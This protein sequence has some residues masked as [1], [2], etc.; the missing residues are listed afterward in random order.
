MSIKLTISILLSDRIDT[1]EKCLESIVPLLQQIPSELILTV[2]GKDPRVKQLAKQYTDHII[3]YTWI[4]DFSHA[5]NQGLMEAKGE[6]FMYMDDDEWFEDVTPIID[7]FNS[8]EYQQYNGATYRKKDYIDWEGKGYHESFCAGLVKRREDLIFIGKVHERYNCIFTPVKEI[9]AFVH[10]YGYVNKKR[11]IGNEK[12]SRNLPLL[13]DMIQ[14]EPNN[15]NVIVQIIQEYANLKDFEKT[16]KYCRIGLAL[17]SEYRSEQNDGWIYSILSRVLFLEYG[18]N[19]AIQVAKEGIEIERLNEAGKMQLYEILTRFYMLIKEYNNAID[20]IENYLS[21]YDQFKKNRKLCHEQTKGLMVVDEIMRKKEEICFLGVQAA[22]QI[23]D[24]EKVQSYLKEFPWNTPSMLYSY[25]NDISN[26][27]E[28]VSKEQ[29]EMLENCLVEINSDDE[30]ILL[31]KMLY[32]H[33]KDRREDVVV[34]YNKLKDSENIRVILNLVWLASI[35]K[36][37]IKEVIQKLNI[38]KW[39]NLLDALIGLVEVEEYDSC[40]ANMKQVLGEDNM[41]YKLLQIRL[42]EQ[43]MLD[44][45]MSGKELVER[46]NEYT[47]I[48]ISYYEKF[49][50]EEILEEDYRNILPA[51]LAFSLYYVESKKEGYDQ[52]EYLKKAKAIY[53]RMLV[54]IKRLME[55]LLREYDRVHSFITPEFQ[56]LG[57]Q[58][59]EQ[60]RQMMQIGQYETALP[61]VSQ[62]VQL[63]PNDLEVLRLKQN[64]LLHM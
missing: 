3:E 15:Q 41:Y 34:Y 5:R 33:K 10:H 30:F 52:I 7:F 44:Q 26:L 56:Q 14:N 13:L 23:K 40:L 28:D 51:E 18:V 27:F 43:E 4:D 8:G 61:I 46:L 12:V 63:M 35:Y 49:Y 25:Y 53:P 59:K 45:Q 24:K 6:W 47:Q 22:L 1:I 32:A 37:D 20:A 42:L 9:D 50:K 38:D 64:I 55:H 11:D 2:T 62:L 31:H 48:V 16:E 36:Y 17:K 19:Y 57:E 29:K 39:K 21:Y 58:V 60:V 54:V